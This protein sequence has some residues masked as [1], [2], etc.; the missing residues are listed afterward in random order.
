MV[1]ARSLQT[2]RW[3]Q[4]VM[5]KPLDHCA[6]QKVILFHNVYYLML[7]APLAFKFHKYIYIDIVYIV[8]GP[9][10]LIRTEQY[11]WCKLYILLL[12]TSVMRVQTTLKRFS[13]TARCSAVQ[14]L[15]CSGMLILAPA[16]TS[17]RRQRSPPFLTARCS[18]YR[19]VILNEGKTIQ[20]NYSI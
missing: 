20:Y 12:C 18:G 2:I 11:I 5:F 1:W 10:N 16:S 14:P 6:T 19:P 7:L 9:N 17:T 4:T 15:F 8:Q 13:L 3:P